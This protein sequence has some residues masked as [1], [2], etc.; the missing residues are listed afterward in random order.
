MKIIIFIS[1][2]WPALV[3]YLNSAANALG[4]KNNEKTVFSDPFPPKIGILSQKQ[5]HDN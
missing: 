3:K 5:T 4:A 1:Y 2:L